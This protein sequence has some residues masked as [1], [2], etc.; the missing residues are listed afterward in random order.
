MRQCALTLPS[1]HFNRVEIF[2]TFVSIFSGYNMS[3]STNYT[4]TAGLTRQH[5]IQFCWQHLWLLVSLYIMTL[6]VALCVRSNLGSSVI[7]SIPMAFAL[8]GE[9]N[10]T[11]GLTIGGYTNVMNVILVALQIVILRRQFAPIQLLQLIIGFLF[12]TLIDMNMWLTSHLDYS[13]LWMQMAAQFAG[14]CVMAFGIALE[15][16]CGSVTMPGEGIQVAI[17][18]VTGKPFAKIKI[19]IDSVLVALAVISCF[20]FWG[21][22]QWNIIGPGTLFAMIFVGAT[23]KALSHHLTWFDNIL[24]YRPGFRRY[25]FGLARFLFKK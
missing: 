20:F 17:A 12:G 13:N 11:F 10:L 24:G 7:S 9:Q 1:L 8:A 25:I 4:A 19:I 18:K 15:V 2:C 21:E 5:L 16:R 23:V 14:C 22:W 3:N 6:G